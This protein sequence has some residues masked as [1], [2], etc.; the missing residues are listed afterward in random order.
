MRSGLLDATLS[1]GSLRSPIGEWWGCRDGRRQTGHATITSP[2]ICL[3]L[4]TRNANCKLTDVTNV[5]DAA[6]QASPGNA[7][8][9]AS[10]T[11]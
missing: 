5:F 3:T 10:N 8:K 9:F 11:F 6:F 2:S 7:A 1:R 4:K